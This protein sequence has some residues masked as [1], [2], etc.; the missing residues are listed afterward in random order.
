MQ[1]KDLSVTSQLQPH[2]QEKKQLKSFANFTSSGTKN[3]D[4]MIRSIILDSKSLIE[5]V[6]TK[7][8][9]KRTIQ[10]ADNVNNNIVTTSL[11]YNFSGIQFPHNHYSTHPQGGGMFNELMCS[12]L[13]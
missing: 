7:A 12:D 9:N 5:D 3:A 8:I 13:F 6:P 4:D 11:V 2:R 1:G 10:M